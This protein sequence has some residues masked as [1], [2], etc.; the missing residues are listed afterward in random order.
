ML[1]RLANRLPIILHSIGVTMSIVIVN[2]HTGENSHA[3]LRLLNY[4]SIERL[5]SALEECAP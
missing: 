2:R 3:W 1:W 5:Q 4:L